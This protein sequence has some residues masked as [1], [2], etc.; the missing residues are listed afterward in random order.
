MCVEI[1][2]EWETR[3]SYRG[4]PYQVR[5]VRVP[6]IPQFFFDSVVYLY[7][8]KE[9]AKAG[10]KFGGSGVLV[11][12]W[13]ET[14]VNVHR[15]H[16]YAV[17]SSHVIRQGNAPVVRL[18]MKD[19]T[20][21]VFEFGQED[22]KSH[23]HGDDVAA[24]LLNPHENLNI[25]VIPREKLLTEKDVERYNIGPGDDTLMVG[26]FINQAG[27]Q[28]NTPSARFGN[29]AMS[30][31]E[32]IKDRRG[33]EQKVFLVETRSLPGY[34]GSPVFLITPPLV[35]FEGVRAESPPSCLLGIDL[36]HIQDEL[37][38]LSKK[39]SKANQRNVPVDKDWFVQMNTGMAHVLPAWKINELLAQDEFEE[40]RKISRKFS[41]SASP[42]TED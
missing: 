15:Q 11:S 38:V 1:S 9:Q 39:E 27:R 14:G 33:I 17:T 31:L 22:W 28:R 13:I 4:Y 30:P 2:T 16:V 25:E 19:G 3:Y 24:C 40:M 7:P 5:K 36:G 20:F 18:N 21:D 29:I 34:S 37:N 23:R 26:R 10:D 35:F 32:S 12:E 8:T 42:I 6:R 41:I